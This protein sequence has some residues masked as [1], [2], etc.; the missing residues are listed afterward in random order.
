[1]KNTQS[2]L[3]Y[4]VDDSVG[5]LVGRVRA[6]FARALD[7]ALEPL[8]IT[9]SQG[10]ILLMLL[11]DRFDTASKLARELYIDAAA[12][13]RMLERLTRLG[14]IVRIPSAADRRAVLLALTPAG[15]SLAEQLTP[16][17]TAVRARNLVG[18][19]EEETGFLKSLLRRI[20]LND[21]AA[22]PQKSSD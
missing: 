14:L 4:C 12:M 5:Y 15:R 10:G 20:L 16:I 7:E 19:S 3:P 11:S 2:P 18:L 6:Q 13:T 21:A 9:H 1:M 22:N 17:F 8:G